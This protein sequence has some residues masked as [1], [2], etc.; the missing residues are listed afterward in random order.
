MVA[1]TI[2]SNKHG[3]VI[4]SNLDKVDN[5][6]HAS[7]DNIGSFYPCLSPIGTPSRSPTISTKALIARFQVA[8]QLELVQSLAYE[9][10]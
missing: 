1:L 5:L 7:R 10:E 8:E 4:V 3:L 9:V 2:F 6:F